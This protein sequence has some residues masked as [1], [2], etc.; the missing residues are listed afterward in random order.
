MTD[1]FQSGK[2]KLHSGKIRGWKIECDNLSDQEIETMVKMAIPRLPSFTALVSVPRGGDRIVKALVPYLNKATGVKPRRLIVDDVLTTGNSIKDRR[3][4]YK[5]QIMT[6]GFVL[7]SC[8]GNLPGWI[9]PLFQIA[10]LK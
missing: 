5:D 3:D 7:F 6:Y 2:F 1:L 10:P 4:Q 8:K 9:I